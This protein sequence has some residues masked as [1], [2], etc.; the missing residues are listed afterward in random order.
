MGIEPGTLVGFQHEHRQQFMFLHADFTI[1]QGE[2]VSFSTSRVQVNHQIFGSFQE[3]LPKGIR[4]HVPDEIA[5]QGMFSRFM[6][7]T[8][9]TLSSPHCHV[10]F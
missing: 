5:L 10:F 6:M 1:Q 9:S 7:A 2:L 8:Q 4:K 3:E